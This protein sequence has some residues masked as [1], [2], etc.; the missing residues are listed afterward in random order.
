MLGGSGSGG[1]GGTQ[2]RRVHGTMWKCRMLPQSGGAARG[3]SGG[4]SGS[5]ATKTYGGGASLG[6][7]PPRYLPAAAGAPTS[8]LTPRGDRDGRYS[9]RAAAA[10]QGGS[11]DAGGASLYAVRRLDLSG[12]VADLGEGGSSQ[13]GTRVLSPAAIL[14]TASKKIAQVFASYA[15]AAGVLCQPIGYATDT[16]SAEIWLVYPYLPHENLLAWWRRRDP[17]ERSESELAVVVKRLLAALASVHG[18]GV[19][20]GSLR[21][22]NVLVNPANDSFVLVNHG[23]HHLEKYLQG[24][25]AAVGLPPSA[26]AAPTARLLWSVPDD[27]AHQTAAPHQRDLW[28]LGLVVCELIKGRH[29]LEGRSARAIDALLRS[30]DAGGALDEDVE[31]VGDNQLVSATVGA[32]ARLSLSLLHLLRALLA[33]AASARPA[34]CNDLLA[35]DPFIKKAAWRRA[36]AG[37][38]G[39]TTPRATAGQSPASAAAAAEAHPARE[40]GG[41]GSG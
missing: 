22:A 1:G 39:S 6:S 26:A 19:V 38:G 17:E 31:R 28:C 8:R 7:S 25:P 9:S 37:R 2:A 13:R 23:L 40:R 34:S 16:A 36:A 24:G 33:R 35:R 3:G 11:A 15:G 14:H 27:V 5:A 18:E 30:P 29:L 20:H 32:G 41:G 10:Q 12:Y 4:V 21:T